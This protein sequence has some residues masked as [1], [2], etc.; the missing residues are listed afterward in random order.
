[1]TI[2]ANTLAV[3]FTTLDFKTTLESKTTWFGPKVTLCVINDGHFHSKTT[4][5][6]RPI[7]LVPGLVLTTNVY[8]VVPLLKAT[9]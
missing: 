5:N 7:S 8:T 2:R 1:M 9:L 6:N 4:G 3:C